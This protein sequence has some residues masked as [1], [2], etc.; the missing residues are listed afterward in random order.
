MN[1]NT[2]AAGLFSAGFVPKNFLVDAEI[3]MQ[4]RYEPK[5]L[6]FYIEIEQECPQPNGWKIEYFNVDA[7]SCEVLNV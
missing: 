7:D 1:N 2:T 4:L 5:P 6:G 3:T